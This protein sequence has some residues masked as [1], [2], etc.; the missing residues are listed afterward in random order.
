M[1]FTKKKAILILNN[2]LL[3]Y[4][5]TLS[6]SNINLVIC[7]VTVKLTLYLNDLS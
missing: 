1:I 5:M 3:K 2:Y 6:F 7:N 4:K